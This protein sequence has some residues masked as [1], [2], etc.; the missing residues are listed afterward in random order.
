MTKLRITEAAVKA[1]LATGTIAGSRSTY[2]FSTFGSS[3]TCNIA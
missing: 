3:A 1:T 2:G